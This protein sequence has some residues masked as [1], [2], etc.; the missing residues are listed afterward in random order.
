MTQAPTIKPRYIAM[1]EFG[2]KATA[3][4]YSSKMEAAIISYKSRTGSTTFSI[5]DAAGVEP[6]TLYNLLSDARRGVRDTAEKATIIG[7]CSVI[8]IEYDDVAK[9]VT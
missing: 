7:I 9:D 8:D 3:R 2:Q 1:A 6:R 5:A 4:I